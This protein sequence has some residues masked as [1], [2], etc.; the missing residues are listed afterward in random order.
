MGEEVYPDLEPGTRLGAYEIKKKLGSGGMGSVYLANGVELK[1][2]VALKVLRLEKLGTNESAR[3]KLVQEAQAAS[4]LNHPNIVTVYQIGSQDG[5][6]FIAMEYVAGHSLQA[7]VPA[8][9]L[10]VHDALQIAIQVADAL[11]IAHEAGLVHRDLKPGNIMIADRGR[12]KVVD[13]GLARRSGAGD[14]AASESAETES[15]SRPGMVTGTSAY[16]SPEQ[17]VGGKVDAR[18]DIWALG[19]VLYRMLSG[20]NAFHEETGVH[21]MAAVL[22]KEPQRLSQFAHGIPAGVERVIQRC[23]AKKLEERWQS[24]GDLRFVLEGLLAPADAAPKKKGIGRGWAVGLLTGAIL[25]G[26]G[27]WLALRST[28]SVAPDTVIRL[29]TR[30]SGLNTE[31]GRAHV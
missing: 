22:T 27:T 28:R 12:V 14:P 6:D 15:M 4:R 30:D 8:A 29:A 24:M 20:H 26:A 31:V 16:M 9:G 17:I 1:R 11:V 7:H 25:A 18:T 23:L 13:F 10:A 5:V 21:T 2:P 3:R 19:C